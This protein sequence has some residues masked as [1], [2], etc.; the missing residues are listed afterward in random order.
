MR[1][2]ET[3]DIDQERE[4]ARLNKY[5]ALFGGGAAQK[6]AQPG[7]V[8][9]A[10]FGLNLAGAAFDTYGAIQQADKAD[11]M[12]ARAWDEYQKQLNMEAEDRRKRDQLQEVKNSFDWANYG[13]GFRKGLGDQY[14]GYFAGIGL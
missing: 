7:W 4:D 13:A 14:G 9:G 8:P 3:I 12:E 6:P 5:A 11:T 10:N 1:Y 2:G